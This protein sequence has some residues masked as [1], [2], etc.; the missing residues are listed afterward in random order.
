MPAPNQNEE[1]FR[2][3][4]LED[5]HPCIMSQTVFGTD[6]YELYTYKDLGSE[7]AAREILV[8][9]QKYLEDND[10]STKEFYSFVAV[11]EGEAEFSEKEFEKLLWQQLQHIH[12][13][14]K[15]D[16]DET[17]SPDTT[18]KSF[19]FSILGS[20][21]YV[22]G[23]HPNSSRNARKSPKP[24]LVFN[25]HSQFEKLRDMGVYQRVRDRIRQRDLVKNGSINPMLIDFGKRSEAPQYSGRQ[26]DESWECPFKHKASK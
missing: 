6:H 24:T 19:S 17:V 21:F 23:L 25:L 4:I 8:D 2:K 14:D 20:A 15:K 18:S 9:L 11:F 12:N 22:V 10:F 5:D 1:R 3:F 7:T 13:L 26:V 16:W